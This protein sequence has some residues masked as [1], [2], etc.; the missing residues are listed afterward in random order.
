MGSE[1][2]YY[3]GRYNSNVESYSFQILFKKLYKI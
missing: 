3:N 1:C 2:K